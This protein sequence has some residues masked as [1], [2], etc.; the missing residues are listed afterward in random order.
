L[1]IVTFNVDSVHAQL[2]YVITP[3]FERVIKA[4]D[5]DILTLQEISGGNETADLTKRMDGI[6]PLPEGG[7]WY[8]YKGTS[9]QMV[10]VI[11]S[12]YPLSMTGDKTDPPAYDGKLE[13]G[14]RDAR[15]SF[16]LVDLPDD[17]FPADLYVSTHHFKSSGG[18][19]NEA[20]RQQEADALVAWWR[21]ART[22]GDHVDVPANTPLV[23]TGDL[24]TVGG[25]QIVATVVSGDIKNN[26]RYGPDVKPDWDD[27]PLTDAK[28]V[29]N[30]IGTDVYTWRNDGSEFEPGRL[31]Y[32]IYSDSVLKA[33]HK[34]VLDTTTM[35]PELLQAAGLEKFDVAEDE[36]GKFDHFPVVVDFRFVGA[37]E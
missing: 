1:R 26:E 12:K 21:D 16:A 17:R 27:T 33:V 31:D 22:P 36:N 6:L 9:P 32:V 7:H 15:V 34:F 13:Y 30:G 25:P 11:A 19:E 14:G 35:S 29:H 8:V 5:P 4:L 18:D 20:A 2:P 37:K 24:N 10:N 23:I 3:K 28:P